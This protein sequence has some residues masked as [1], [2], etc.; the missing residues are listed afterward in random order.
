MSN[1]D[2]WERRSYWITFYPLWC[3]YII[4][5]VPDSASIDMWI[6]LGVLGVGITLL[7]GHIFKVTVMFFYRRL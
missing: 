1:Y 6:T 3:V 7:W 2:K 5:G 4:F